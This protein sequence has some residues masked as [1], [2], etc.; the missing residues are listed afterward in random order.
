ME[1]ERLVSIT[2][3]IPKVCRDQLRKI[4]AQMNLKNPDKVTSVSALG[5]EIFC[6]YLEKLQN[7]GKGDQRDE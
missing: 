5:K 4:V 3:N 1:T 2:I 7:R 6:E